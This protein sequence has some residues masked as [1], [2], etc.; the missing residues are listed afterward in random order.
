MICLLVQNAM[1]G[2]A[3]HDGGTSSSSSVTSNKVSYH[4]EVVTMVKRYHVILDNTNCCKTMN[5][6]PAPLNVVD[7]S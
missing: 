5:I 3:T 4:G 7:N 6:C 1:V 2:M